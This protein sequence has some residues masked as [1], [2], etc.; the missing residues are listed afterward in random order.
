MVYRGVQAFGQIDCTEEEVDKKMEG[1]LYRL[2]TPSSRI[3]ASRT[4]HRLERN[5][6]TLYNALESKKGPVLSK[7]SGRFYRKIAGSPTHRISPQATR[8]VFQDSRDY[9]RT[10]GRTTMRTKAPSLQQQVEP[11]Q[12]KGRKT[13]QTCKLTTTKVA[14][15]PPRA[16]PRLKQRNNRVEVQCSTTPAT[17]TTPNSP[18]PLTRFQQF[19]QP[20]P[21]AEVPPFFYPA[22][23]AGT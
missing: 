12:M 1:R 17:V 13:K 20:S 22:T 2:H 4:F 18:G 14:A 16:Q 6:R 10:M 8:N 21:A 11:S 19:A 3:Q 15:E 9:A 7:S 5:V 23:T